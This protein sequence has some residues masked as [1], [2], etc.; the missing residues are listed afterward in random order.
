MVLQLDG[1]NTCASCSA[2]RRGTT[3]AKE[4]QHGRLFS[5]QNSLLNISTNVLFTKG[6]LEVFPLTTIFMDGRNM[7][8]SLFTG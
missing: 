3:E 1:R 7:I 8:Y 4:I 6:G 2:Q 5:Q